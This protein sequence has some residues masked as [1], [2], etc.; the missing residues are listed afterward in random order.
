MKV[1]NPD[2]KVSNSVQLTLHDGP[3]V[4]RVFS[5]PSNDL[6]GYF[7]GNGSPRFV[8][9]GN[10]VFDTCIGVP[11]S[12]LP[13][14]VSFGA[15][16][17]LA[18][19]RYLFTV[20]A[21]SANTRFDTCWSAASDCVQGSTLVT[22]ATGAAY[23]AD[24]RFLAVWKGV[25][26]LS[27]DDPGTGPGV[28]LLDTC[29]NAANCTPHS[30]R[31]GSA[32][33]NPYSST[34]PLFVSD[35]W[36]Y[37]VWQGYSAN[38]IDTF[39]YDT[40]IGTTGTCTVGNTL[41]QPNVDHPFFSQPQHPAP[42]R[43]NVSYDVYSM[44]GKPQALANATVSDNC[45]GVASCVSNSVMM[46]TEINTGYV[47]T[48][49]A[50]NRLSTVFLSQDGRYAGYGMATSWPV[51]SP[52]DP[53]LCTGQQWEVESGRTCLNAGRSCTPQFY[54]AVG[55]G[56]G[57]SACADCRPSSLS[58]DGSYITFTSAANLLPGASS[59]HLNL[60]IARTK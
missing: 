12:C 16:T 1:A 13:T 48:F 8:Q 37:A 17:W 59:Q 60:Y 54:P 29:L 19:G 50:V 27:P 5:D 10:S 7:V 24:G 41:L 40:C 14:S 26:Q 34:I 32:D 4:I 53:I 22:V 33:Y 31:M 58:A 2:G 57:K 35:D 6:D 51:Q 47:C 39:V 56:N 11:G 25:N 28:F 52:T 44:V 9:A 38:S 23:S 42:G 20:D 15:S 46:K 43:F 55:D 18:A 36:R 45:S 3:A 21:S 49:Y 30:T